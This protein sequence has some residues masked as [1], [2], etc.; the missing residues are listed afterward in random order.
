MLPFNPDRVVL[1]DRRRWNLLSSLRERALEVLR[2]LK[3][4]RIE[5][6]A[7]GSLARGD[8]SEGSDVDV[9]V[10]RPPRP[11]SILED[12]LSGLG[13]PLER[14]IVQSTPNSAVKG[15]I[16][17]PNRVTVSFPL[18]PLR[19]REEEFYR[20]GGVVSERDLEG[21]VRRPGV[22]KSLILVFPTPD[23]H[24]ELDVPGRE[25]LVA[26][27]VGVSVETVRERVR[28]LGRR[29]VVGTTGIYASIVLGEF[30][31]FEDGLLLLMR[32]RKLS[33]KRIG[34]VF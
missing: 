25:S 11:I 13:C 20:F 24:A 21:G 33:R 34:E 3:K 23:G 5:A 19:S 31:E 12:A 30:Q 7:Y 10:P 15:Y 2:S 8:V 32:S 26:R 17:L 4:L 28:V 27:I 1:Y 9:F 6:F 14:R 29:R 18:V 22:N 16:T